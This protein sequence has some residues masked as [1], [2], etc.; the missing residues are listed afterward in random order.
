LSQSTQAHAVLKTDGHDRSEALH[1]VTIGLYPN[2]QAG[3]I[4]IRM[5]KEGST[6]AGL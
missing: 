2:G 1:Y 5:A 3:A 4:F 6:F